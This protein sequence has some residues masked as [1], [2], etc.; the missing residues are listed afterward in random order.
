[1]PLLPA[2]CIRIALEQ[3][4]FPGHFATG[5]EMPADRYHIDGGMDIH[6]ISH[7]TRINS[8]LSFL[9]GAI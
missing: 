2:K 8:I 5:D 3:E 6:S 1:V 9:T 4:L 7:R